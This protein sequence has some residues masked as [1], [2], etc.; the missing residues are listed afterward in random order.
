MWNRAFEKAG[1]KDAIIVKDPPDDPDFDPE[2]VRYNTIRWITSTDPS[3][4]AI[5]PSRV[6]PRNG[7]ILDADILVEAA[8][9]QSVRRGY[10]NYVSTL[11]ASASSSPQYFSLSPFS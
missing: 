5:G 8:F 4:G 6:D 7:H 1:F 9:I 11:S 10:R 2:D 3:F